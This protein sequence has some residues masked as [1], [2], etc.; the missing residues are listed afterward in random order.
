MPGVVLRHRLCGYSGCHGLF[1]ICVSCDRGQRYCSSACRAAARREQRSRA[2]RRYQ[3]GAAGRE[4][5]RKCQQR[6]RARPASPLV[7]DQPGVSLSTPAE[8]T[9]PVPRACVDLDRT[10]MFTSIGSRCCSDASVTVY[11]V[12]E[13]WNQDH[14]AALAV[15]RSKPELMNAFGRFGR[16]VS[17][18]FLSGSAMSA[19][20]RRCFQ[21]DRPALR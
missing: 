10:S 7:T 12:L 13:L 1:T 18:I 8:A 5:H 9:S 15:R 17:Q 2:N 20:D 4:A 6:Y 11:A 14:G 3:E 21:S 16:A 19:V